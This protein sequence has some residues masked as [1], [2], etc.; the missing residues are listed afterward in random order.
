MEDPAPP[1]L[2]FLDFKRKL[3]TISYMMTSIKKKIYVSQHLFNLSDKRIK[4]QDRQKEHANQGHLRVD[5][6]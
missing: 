1:K 2:S 3:R 5:P 4:C 6:K